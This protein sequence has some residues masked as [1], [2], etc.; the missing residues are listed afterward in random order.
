MNDKM[1]HLFITFTV[2]DFL[3]YLMMYP[4]DPQC[5]RVQH[6]ENSFREQIISLLDV[7][8]HFT[9]QS[10]LSSPPPPSCLE[11]NR[12]CYMH[13]L[14][15]HWQVQG[16]YYL[17]KH[18]VNLRLKIP[19]GTLDFETNQKLACYS[20]K[21]LL[22]IFHRHTDI[23]IFTWFETLPINVSILIH[24]LLHVDYNYIKL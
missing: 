18:G 9:Q 24:I 14:Q 22:I 19:P 2:V 16:Q 21:C 17:S 5:L 13:H 6:T 15:L 23:C 3:S 1:I 20:W 7:C 12:V 8:V 4:N 10:V 11:G